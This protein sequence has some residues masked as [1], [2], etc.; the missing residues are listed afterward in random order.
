MDV[1]EVGGGGRQWGSRGSCKSRKWLK[2]AKAE[3]D[4]VQSEAR[5]SGFYAGLAE[6]TASGG[7]AALRRGRWGASGFGNFRLLSMGSCR[8]CCKKVSKMAVEAEK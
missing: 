1:D 3:H 8:G 7:A 4:A 6:N 5:E 2:T